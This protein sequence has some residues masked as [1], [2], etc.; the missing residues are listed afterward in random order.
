MDLTQTIEPK[1]DQL[2]ADDLISGPRTV[3]I[4]EVRKGS[5]EQ[6]VN[7]VLA[8]FG[9]DRPYKPSKS[10]RR[11]MVAA[12]GAESSVYTGRS[13][14][15]YRDPKITFGPDEVGGIRISHLSHID[16]PLTMALTVKRGKR[17]PY[18]VQPLEAVAP[19]PDSITPEQVREVVAGFDN[20]GITERADRARF[21]ADT[22]GHEVAAQ[23]MTR[24]Q[25]DSVIFALRAAVEPDPADDTLPMGG[26][27]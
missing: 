4:T 6:P 26:E 15:L 13:M 17:Q 1:S 10:M 24:A 25:A 16:K 2:N 14:T 7:V 21:I 3:T 23:D 19:Q 27:S 8:E 11:V 9:P 20:L 22:L 5:N 18:R 12:W